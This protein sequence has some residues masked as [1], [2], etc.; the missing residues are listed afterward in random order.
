MN[1]RERIALGYTVVLGLTVIGISSGII[2]GNRYQNRA[3]AVRKIATTKRQLLTDLQVKIL[4]NRPAKQL[5]PYLENPT[6]FQ[7]E[8]QAFIDRITEIQKILQAYQNLPKTELSLATIAEVDRQKLHRNLTEYQNT[9]AD[10]RRLTEVFAR[11]ILA[12]ENNATDLAIAQ[13]NLLN[14]V[15]SSEF[16]DFIE[17]PDKL[18]KFA[19]I[20]EQEEVNAE[21]ALQQASILRNQ[22]IMG[23]LILSVVMATL[24]ALYTSNAIAQPVQTV[25]YLAQRVTKEDNFNLQATVNSKGEMAILANSLNQLITKVKLLLDQLQ[26]KNTDLEVALTQLN[27]QQSHLIQSE[28]MSSLGELVAGIAHEINNP[29]NFIHG[30]LHH[31][32]E[33]TEDLLA[34][35]N[36]YQKFY[37]HP[38]E[39]IQN[40]A[41]MIDFA[42]LREDLLKMLNSMQ[43]GTKRI[44]NIVLSL[45]NF[46][47]LDES[48]LKEVDLHEGIDGT[49]LILQHRLKETFERPSISIQKDYSS[50]PLVECYPGH[51]NQVVMNILSNAIDAIE[52]KYSQRS[53]EKIPAPPQ[54]TIRTAVLNIDWVEMAIA[55]NGIGIP[56]KIQN[57]IF[58]PFFTTKPIGKG[59][60]MGMS[61]SYQIITQQHQGKLF[62]HST[63][64]EETEFVIQIPRRLS[65]H[66]SE[67]P[68]QEKQ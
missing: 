3:V 9:V 5:V 1:I 58:N 44:R 24:V 7:K 11:D 64:S 37:P 56:P 54:I 35:V 53:P 55:D 42:F 59:T 43:E 15:Q 39:E 63:P 4:Y 33:Y 18:V 25:T 8:S 47:R 2:V 51:L 31:L 36:L 26:D 12:L 45:R 16:V 20:I 41:E 52:A 48:E 49:L 27:Q 62:F 19:A 29:V 22:I 6:L 68:H 28:K 46:S 32:Q 34:F 14:F 60:G 21:I 38:D 57:Q 17:F 67:P 13:Q 30:N 23:S 66:Q 65:R 40:H 50:L 61:I 10:F